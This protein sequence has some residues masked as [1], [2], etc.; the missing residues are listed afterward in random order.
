MPT[1]DHSFTEKS[2]ENTF[3]RRTASS[4][5][6]H[7][8]NTLSF[9][10]RRPKVKAAECP[11]LFPNGNVVLLALISSRLNGGAKVESASSKELHTGAKN[12]ILTAKQ[13]WS[14]NGALNTVWQNIYVSRSLMPK[15]IFVISRV[16]EPLLLLRYSLNVTNAQGE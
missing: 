12:N 15:S 11:F 14:I 4:F 3:Y 1:N 10:Q 6:R 13:K 5:S 7:H 8:S 2:L 9:W 16:G